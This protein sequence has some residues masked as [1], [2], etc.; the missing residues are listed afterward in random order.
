MKEDL[1]MM[2]E[3][4][5]FE[6]KR[7][8]PENLLKY[9]FS[10]KEY[11]Y[12]YESD[13][14]NGD[15]RAVIEVS[16]SGAITGKVMDV[17]NEEEYVQLRIEN[18]SNA[19]VGQVRSEYEKILSDIADACCVAVLFASDQANRITKKISEKYDISP[20]FPWEQGQYQGYGAFRHEKSKKWFALIMN[21]KM[22]MLLKDKTEETVDVIN[23]KVSSQEMEIMVVKKGIYHGY[24]MNH[25]HWVS[26]VLDETLSDDEVMELVERSFYLT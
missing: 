21:I 5:I 25:K 7:F 8:I 15:F 14:M 22:A 6:R 18:L 26:V 4:R 2:L 10:Y 19:Y 1:V 3:E 9:G 11:G 23:L 20:D 12:L 17:M 24:H 13:F 16:K